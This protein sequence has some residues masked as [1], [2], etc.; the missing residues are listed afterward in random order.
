MNRDEARELFA[1]FYGMFDEREAHMEKV[2]K[3]SMKMDA[4][5]EDCQKALDKGF[6]DILEEFTTK[7]ED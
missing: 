3:I 1:T 4:M 7:K 6:G 5:I 2:N